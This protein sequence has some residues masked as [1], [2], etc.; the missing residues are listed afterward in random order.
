M[1]SDYDMIDILQK[2]KIE[3]LNDSISSVDFSIDN[4]ELLDDFEILNEYIE[5]FP[6]SGT[7]TVEHIQFQKD[8]SKE[9]PEDHE[10]IEK[11]LTKYGDEWRRLGED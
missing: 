3:M 5:G 4:V 1:E 10:I 2:L 11:F 6:A 9:L 8:I 7:E